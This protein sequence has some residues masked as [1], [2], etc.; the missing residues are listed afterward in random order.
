MGDITPTAMVPVTFDADTGKLM[1]G[2]TFG[3]E[4]TRPG[5]SESNAMVTSTGRYVVQKAE[6]LTLF[7]YY[8]FQGNYN[9]FNNNDVHYDDVSEVE[10]KQL[11]D[12]TA[13]FHF[14]G[15]GPIG[16]D[17]IVP[18]QWKIPQP[19]AGLTIYE[20]QSFV[21]AARN[22]VEMDIDFVNF[23][24]ANMCLTQGCA[25]EE[26]AARLGYAAW[27]MEKAF[28]RQLQEAIKREQIHGQY[29][30][31]IAEDATKAVVDC[32]SAR[33]A[34]LA[35]QPALPTESALVEARA[36]TA[37]CLVGLTTVLGAL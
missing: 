34:L 25:L 8:L 32:R 10:L 29:G 14:F 15:P 9:F 18:E 7:Y 21:T 12:L 33:A 37:D 28:Q 26:A 35:K 4:L 20:P 5:T 13:Q 23:A 24:T 19:E 11:Q 30:K 3:P 22:Q 2:Q 1:P 17:G 6:L 27:N 31:N 16:K 36:R